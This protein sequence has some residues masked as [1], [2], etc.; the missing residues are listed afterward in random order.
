MTTV[1]SSNGKVLLDKS[2]R[3]SLDLT[4]GTVFRVRTENNTIVL[5]PVKKSRANGIII[6]DS[7]STY[8]VLSADC[9]VPLLTND[10]V[11]KILTDFP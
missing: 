5:D 4:P 2:L 8:S 11:K 3:I 9:E 10:R 6:K 1:L 7:N